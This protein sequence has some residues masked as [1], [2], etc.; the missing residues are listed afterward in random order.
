MTNIIIKERLALVKW[1][2]VRFDTRLSARKA[3]FHS[4]KKR[5]LRYEN[6]PDPK[7][8]HTI[9]SMQLQIKFKVDRLQIMVVAKKYIYVIQIVL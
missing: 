7:V 5:H 2:L 1:T 9:Y 4:P 8:H 6:V 3:R